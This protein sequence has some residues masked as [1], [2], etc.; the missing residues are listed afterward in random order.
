MRD[1]RHA[2]RAIYDV[3]RRRGCWRN[4]GV[5]FQPFSLRSRG[6]AAP[7]I[8]LTGCTAS[9]GSF[10]YSVLFGRARPLSRGCTSSSQQLDDRIQA[11]FDEIGQRRLP[12]GRRGPVLPTRPPS[13]IETTDYEGPIVTAWTCESSVE[14][15]DSIPPSRSSPGAKV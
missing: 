13:T 2:A 10:P 6:I 12:M 14:T 15:H 11:R 3:A 7:V 8:R 9:Q 5:Y 1:G 4:S